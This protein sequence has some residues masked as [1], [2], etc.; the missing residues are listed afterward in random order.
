LKVERAAGKETIE[1]RNALTVLAAVL[2]IGVGQ[3][4]AFPDEVARLGAPLDGTRNALTETTMGDLVADAIRSATEADFAFVQA[5]ALQ[6]VMITQKTLSSDDLR[7]MLVF[8][9]EAIVVLRLD[10]GRIRAAL[11]R[12]LGVL[13]NPSKGFLQVSG[14]SV[15]FDSS[16]APGARVREIVVSKT[17]AAL[18]PKTTYRVAM[19][20]SL[21]KGA[22]GY[23]RVFNR[24]PQEAVDITLS[25]ALTQFA[26]SQSPLSPRIEGRIRPAE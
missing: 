3:A 9:D 17:K 11:E 13:P 25:Q 6:P 12:S 5:S 21:A 2:W 23:F 22:L 18:D 20:A 14:L 19:P 4:N 1:M 15:R 8:P 10:G 7:A 26:A 16:Q 24:A